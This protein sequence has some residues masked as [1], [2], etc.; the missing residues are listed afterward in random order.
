MAQCDQEGNKRQNGEA[1]FD[2]MVIDWTGSSSQALHHIREAAKKIVDKAGPSAA[3]SPS[4][5]WISRTKWK[6][7]G[8]TLLGRRR[9]AWPNMDPG[10]A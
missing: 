10:L 9:S 8:W 1:F 6:S 7:F 4:N 3:R 5:A 2:D